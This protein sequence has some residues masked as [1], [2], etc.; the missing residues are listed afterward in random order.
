MF[1]VYTQNGCPFCQQ[2]IQFL[3]QAGVP[4]DVIDVINDPILTSGIKV[5]L[6]DGK[7]NIKDILKTNISV[8]IVVCFS[9]PTIVVGMDMEK[10]QNVVN[11]YRSFSAESFAQ[12]NASSQAA[13]VVENSSEQK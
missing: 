2:A 11:N 4:F 3:Q 6:N 7:E 10:L 13:P 8:P 5:L 1:R 9:P 12:P